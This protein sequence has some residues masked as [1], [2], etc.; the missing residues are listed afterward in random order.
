MIYLRAGFDI[1]TDLGRQTERSQEFKA[2]GLGVIGK[3]PDCAI[4]PNNPK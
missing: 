1:G 2:H 3:F 4:L